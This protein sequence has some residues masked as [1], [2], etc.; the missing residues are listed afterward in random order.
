M[1]FDKILSPNRHGT[2]ALYNNIETWT[3][4]GAL[5]TRD[6]ENTP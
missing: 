1:G 6:T 2:R 3:G 4:T 5:I